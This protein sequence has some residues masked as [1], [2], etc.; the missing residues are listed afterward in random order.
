MAI[1]LSTI[2]FT[3]RADVVPAFG[4]EEILNT[5]I[6]NTL[7]G[8]DTITG[9]G[10]NGIS[11]IYN[12]GT[13]NTADGN[14]IITG[15]R[16][17]NENEPTNPLSAGIR[18]EGGTIDTG[19]GNDIITGIHNQKKDSFFGDGI[20]NG[21]GGTIDTGDGND[22]ITGISQEQGGVGITNQDGTIK[23]GDG[24]DIITA[25]GR[26]GL[27]NI[28]ILDTGDGNDTI[29]GNSTAEFGVGILNQSEFMDTGD[30]N[31]IITGTGFVSIANTMGSTLNTGDGNDTI[32]A[33]GIRDG[34]ENYG[35]INTGKGNDSIIADGGFGGDFVGN[36]SVFLGDGKDYLKGFGSGNFDGGNGKDTLE[37]TSGSYTVGISATG[38][39]FTKGS[40]IMNTSGFEEL[41][42]G[43][44][45]YDFSRL[46]N[47]QTIVVA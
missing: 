14:D 40:I 46:T 18:N 43:N 4:V 13:L 24:N 11:G 9:T 44:T 32:T 3:N 27:A 19:D 35:I 20:Y 1:E 8:K 21:N 16:N 6:A 31:D 5:G 2:T 15:T 41:I 25:I 36:G 12:I 38:V 17:Q 30:G 34:I 33:I 28:S 39:N 26:F 10:G 29:T 23:T 42:A 22:T 7:A 45:K 37:L 47:G